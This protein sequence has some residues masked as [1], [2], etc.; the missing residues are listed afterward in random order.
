MASNKNQ[1][2]VPRCYLRPF[3]LNDGKTISLYNLDRDKAI[4]NSPLKN[5]CSGDYF[6]GKDDNLE[7]AIQLIESTYAGELS[8]LLQPGKK[9]SPTAN[10]ILPRFWLLQQLRTEAASRRTAEMSSEADGL[11]KDPTKSES[12]RLH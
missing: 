4:F 3:S 8:A 2:F 5:Q 7:R 9:L 12:P 11:I 6:Y 10:T 1:H